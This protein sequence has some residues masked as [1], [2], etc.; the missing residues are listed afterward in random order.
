MIGH[1]VQ[2]RLRIHDT[3]NMQASAAS[4]FMRFDLR[5]RGGGPVLLLCCSHLMMKQ[6]KTRYCCHV[7][8]VVAD[9]G[10]ACIAR[11]HYTREFYRLAF[12]SGYGWL[13]VGISCSSSD[14]SSSHNTTQAHTHTHTH[15]HGY[16]HAYI[17]KRPNQAEPTRGTERMRSVPFL[18][19][20]PRLEMAGGSKV[21]LPDKFRSRSR[22]PHDAVVCIHT[23]HQ[24]SD[25]NSRGGG[26]TDG[27]ARV[28]VRVQYTVHIITDLMLV[29]SV[30]W[31]IATPPAVT[32]DLVHHLFRCYF[33]TVA[34]L[35][36]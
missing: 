23:T 24:L 19:D 25:V 9:G 32:S 8:S 17:L 13:F 14:A 20:D 4:S 11:L 29:L 2:T 7:H 34:R 30:L 12:W 3:V 33:C 31:Q 15:T 26:D 27:W 5:G 28:R 36:A 1:S 35:G 18:L 6:R 22:R 16:L 10:F 21:G